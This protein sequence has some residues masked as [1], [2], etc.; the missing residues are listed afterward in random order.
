M[1][2]TL[3]ITS[4]QA[5]GAERVMCIL[6]NAWAGAGHSVTLLTFDNAPPFYPLDAS[7]RHFPLGLLHSGLGF[8]PRLRRAFVRHIRLRE[9]IRQSR[10]EAVISFIETT[11]IRTLLACLG[12]GLSV[13]V[14][15]R[16]HPAMHAHTVGPVWNALRRLTY[17]L[18]KSVVIQSE[19]VRTCLPLGARRNAVVIP[20]PVLSPVVDSVLP[21]ILLPRPCVLCVGRLSAEKGQDVLLKAF[22]LVQERFPQWN[23]VLVGDGP[24]R[25]DL[26]QLAE[27]L[28]IKNAVVFAGKVRAVDQ[29]YR[30]ADIYVCP[31]HYEGFPNALCEAMAHGLPVV[32]TDAP[33][34]MGEIVHHGVSGILVPVANPAALAEGLGTLL[35]DVARRNTLGQRARSVADRFSPRLVLKMWEKLLGV[36]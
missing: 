8:S 31:S 15:E 13:V 21:P 27:R 35:G 18:A 3:V 28:G 11:N 10:P 5:G 23:L 33:G 20:N 34:A 36:A 19:A 16:T 4:L 9:A 14:S 1:R 7:V 29:Y 30:Q 26:E 17:P 22:A 24:A 6:A 25:A 12:L 32:A 2:L